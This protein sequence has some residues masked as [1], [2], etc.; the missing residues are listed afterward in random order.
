MLIPSYHYSD[1]TDEL[2]TIVGIFTYFYGLETTL[3]ERQF[4]RA[5]ARLVG[6]RAARLAACGIAA[7]ATRM[8]FTEEG[9][10]VAADGSLYSVRDTGPLVEHILQLIGAEISWICRADT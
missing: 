10:A 5:I 2:L 8:E 4:F 3:A 6:R 9:C 1:T 7:L